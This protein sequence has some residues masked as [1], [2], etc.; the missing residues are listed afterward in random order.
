LELFRT[1]ALL[2]PQAQD[3]IRAA[4]IQLILQ[5]LVDR[6]LTH[7][8]T[9]A[10]LEQQLISIYN[11]LSHQPKEIIGYAE[12]NLLDIFDRLQTDFP[13]GIAHHVSIHSVDAARSQLAAIES[14]KSIDNPCSI[15]REDVWLS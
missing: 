6:L 12:E 5:P 15:D 9:R 11:A 13:G 7:F 3:Y 14:S 1:H 4:Q 10:S 2:E 8:T